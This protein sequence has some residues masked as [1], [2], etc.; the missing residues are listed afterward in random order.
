MAAETRNA[1][2]SAGARYDMVDITD[3]LR[4]H[5]KHQHRLVRLQV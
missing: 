2:I 5:V 4:I 3:D 1:Y